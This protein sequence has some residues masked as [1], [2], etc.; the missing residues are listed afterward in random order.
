[1]TDNPDIREKRPGSLRDKTNNGVRPMR[2]DRSEA[3]G[4]TDDRL[5]WNGP[6]GGR[7]PGD[8]STRYSLCVYDTQSEATKPCRAAAHVLQNRPPKSVERGYRAG[9]SADPRIVKGRRARA[10]WDRCRKPVPY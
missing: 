10:G 1:L 2:R 6:M 8:C 3:D 5:C 7:W 4:G 9:Q